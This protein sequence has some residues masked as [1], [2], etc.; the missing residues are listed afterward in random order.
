MK[1]IYKGGFDDKNFFEAIEKIKDIDDPEERI[2]I[3]NE[4][5]KK[6]VEE[7]FDFD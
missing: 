6:D 7:M 3:L 2:R 1:P 4:S 5:A